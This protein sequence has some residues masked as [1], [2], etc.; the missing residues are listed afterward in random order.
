M[1]Y[2]NSE[3]SKNSLYGYLALFTGFWLPYCKFMTYMS[4][5]AKQRD[6]HVNNFLNL[7]YLYMLTFLNLFLFYSR[8]EMSLIS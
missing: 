3:C 6:L 7:F 5:D 8:F 2:R 4:I 1:V